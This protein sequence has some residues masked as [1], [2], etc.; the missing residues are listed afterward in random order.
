MREAR[1]DGR[2]NMPLPARAENGEE[3]V[4]EDDEDHAAP[5]YRLEQLSAKVG[6]VEPVMA[7]LENVEWSG[8]SP[9]SLKRQNQR[10][11]SG[12]MKE[13]QSQSALPL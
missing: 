7:H 4:E 2:L 6:V 10:C 9:S 12:S 13:G 1:F 3:H 11:N 8:T 5:N